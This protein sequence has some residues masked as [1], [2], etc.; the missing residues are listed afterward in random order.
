MPDVQGVSAAVDRYL[1][2]P[3]QQDPAV[4]VRASLHEAADANPETEAEL[5]RVSR[6][7]GVPL[8]SARAFPADVRRQALLQ[9]L[10]ANDTVRQFPRT[11]ALLADVDNARIAHDDIGNLTAIERAVRELRNVGLG[12]LRGGMSVSPALM[13]TRGLRAREPT[14]IARAAAEGVVGQTAG[15]LLSGIGTGL[16]IGARAIDRPVRRMFGNEVADLFWYEPAR[17]GGVALDPLASFREGGQA[18]EQL[19]K[20]IGP[21]SSERGFATDVA[22]GLGQFAG[23]AGAHILSGGALTLPMLYAQGL[24][25]FEQK[26]QRDQADQIMKDLGMLGAAG[27][28]AATEKWALDRVLGP[29]AVPVKSALAAAAARIGIAAASEGG[30]EMAESVGH[31]LLRMALTNPDAKID[32]LDVAYEGGVGA[33]VGG[34]ARSVLEAALHVRHRGARGDWQAGSAEQRAQ[35]LEQLQQLA[36]ASKT[37][38]RDAQT[39]Q[40]FVQQVA[41]EGGDTPTELFVAPQQLAG[42]LN[43]SGM[44][45]A[46]LQAVAP[47][48]AAQVAAA[49]PGSDIRLPLAEFVALGERAAPLIDHVR[50]GDGEMTRA[51][52]R[53]ATERAG[54]DFRGALDAELQ[55]RGDREAFRA[56]V[57]ALRGVIEQQFAAAGRSP[58]VARQEA[59]ILA[60]FYGAAAA[61]TGMSA[62]AFAQ[63]YRLASQRGAAPATA[64]S[65]TM[66]QAARREIAAAKAALARIEAAGGVTSPND[67]AAVLRVP[68]FSFWARSSVAGDVVASTA[69][70]DELYRRFPVGSIKRDWTLPRLNDQGVI[71]FD[72]EWARAASDE[73]LAAV[74]DLAEAQGA[75]AVMRGDY[76]DQRALDA[77]DRRVSAFGFE[78]Y[79]GLTEGTDYR[80]QSRALPIYIRPGGGITP[81]TSLRQQAW[82]GTPH[83][84]IERFSTDKIGTGEGA[85]AFAGDSPRAQISF[86]RDLTTAPSV[87]SFLKGADRSSGIHE[88]GHFFLQVHAD[89]AARIQAR[90]DAGEQVGDGERGIVEDM[91]TTL[92]W[93]GIRD[94]PEASALMQ[95]HALTLDQQRQ[96]HE[97]W[98]RGFERYAMEGKAPSVELMSAFSRFRAWLVDLYKRLTA[99]NVELSDD[100]RAVMGRMLATDEAVEEMEAVRNMAPMVKTAEDAARLGWTLDDYRAYQARGKEATDAAVSDLSARSQ[101]DL[102]WASRARD[103]ALKARQAEVE[104]LRRQVRAEVRLEVLSE[105]LYRAWTFLTGKGEPAETATAAPKAAG[106]DVT[107]DSLLNAIAHLGGLDREAARQDLGVHADDWKT[108]SGIFGK[109][110]FRKEG[111]LAPERMIE[112]LTD[113]A[114]LMP[115]DGLHEL[116]Q[117]IADELHGEPQY[118]AHHDYGRVQGDQAAQPLPEGV[119]FGKLST[120]M[121]REMYGAGEDAVWRKLSA[122]RMTSD[123]GIDPDVVAA[124]IMNDMGEPAF[125]SGDAL[126]QALAAAVPPAEVIE[127]RTDRRMLEQYGDIASPEA[128]QR[129][130]DEAVH[131]EARARFIADELRALREAGRAA[132]PDGKLSALQLAAAAKAYAEQ[133]VA[134]QRVRDLRPGQ[135]TAAEARSA[136]LAETAF[137]KGQTAEAAMHKRNQL[138]NHAAAK[139]ALDAKAEVAATI[140]SFRRFGKRINGIDAEHQ[141]QIETLLEAFNFRPESQKAADRRAAFAKWYA[142]QEE[143]GQAPDGLAEL[144]DSRKSYQDM[145]VAELRDLLAAVRQIEHL[146]RL[147]NRLLTAR[148]RRDFDAAADEAAASIRQHG[149]PERPVEMEGPNKAADWLAGFAAEHRKLSSYV[150]QMDGGAEDGPMHRL[151]GRGLNERSVAEDKMIEEAVIALEAIHRPVLALRGGLT[152]HRSKMSIPGVGSLTRAGRISFALNMGNAQ[153]RQRLESEFTPQQIDAVLRT[154]TPTELQFVNDIW[155]YLETYWPLIAAKERRL[156]GR[157]PEKVEAVP[158]EI[159]AAGG[160]VVPMTGGYYPIKYDSNRSD[161]AAKQ[162]AVEMAKRTLQGAWGH[163]T[164]QRGHTKARQESVSLPLRKDLRV[165]TEHVRQVTHDLSWHEWLIDANRLLNDRR[166]AGAIR[167]HYGPRAL[168]AIRDNID[169]IAAGDLK[170]MTQVDRAFLALRNN[171]TRSVMGASLRTAFLQPFGLLQSMARIGAGP[172]L[173]GLARWAGDAARLESTARKIYAKSDFMRRRAKTFNREMHEIHSAIDGKSKA[174]RAI[175]GGLFWLTQKMQLVSDIPTWLGQYEKTLADAEMADSEEGR[176][177]LEARAIEAAD[178]AVRESQGTGLSADLSLVQR[179]HP[180]LTQFYSYFNVTANLA[181]EKT[182]AT[183]FR[184]P[185]AVAGWLGDMALLAVLP[186]IVPSLLMHAL[187]GGGDDDEPG[188][189]AKNIAQWQAGYLLGMVVGARELSGPVGGFDYAG[190][191]AF[192]IFHDMGKAGAQTWQLVK[193]AWDGDAADGIDEPFVLAYARLLGDITGLPMTQILRSYKGWKAWDEGEEGAGPQSVLIG[194]PPRD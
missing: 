154:L 51:E 169:A 33:A 38:A 192:R 15:T 122:R 142:Q 20:R 178:R 93:F 3:T 7:T 186:S 181:A 148:D 63:T 62:Q 130:A 104:G 29:L 30:Q 156:T 117:K 78:P 37:L 164:T 112:A 86:P 153:N 25:Q 21:S 84:G 31:D 111:G 94:A 189:W 110:V 157:E 103:R 24:R 125:D 88:L 119:A 75:P 160:A 129:A 183:D 131:N 44:T 35:G 167:D 64:D 133:V 177:E 9:R 17:A 90:I 87:L 128:L 162:S 136:K 179:K 14:N 180:L 71:T 80:E 12:M 6:E 74:V 141:D 168:K 105:P 41:E 151:L 126:V 54:E 175:D 109:P 49:V 132:G 135:Y 194:P 193:S 121:L 83:R 2:Q 173:R 55:R 66:E 67:L 155:A 43:Q 107:R 10:D 134:S 150:R 19:G 39:V 120:P 57:D 108:P 143:T 18:L 139:A 158:F 138:A 124:S 147:K 185:R 5:R 118:S 40:S 116:E 81:A 60:E 46:E 170:A 53:D 73:D 98:A 101:R 140:R 91:R 97:Q 188:D 59:S 100:M 123:T 176:A 4:A 182:A 152:G 145:T 161:A 32:A 166:V 144:L 79:R 28:T 89:L 50:V 68:G 102:R 56:E 171:V 36:A 61:R 184:N 42:V 58:A 163:A 82:H 113:N 190:P 99:L 165:V 85:Q 106:L 187:T 191:P 8:G 45:I 172:T 174:V 23:Q 77:L 127:A 149:G 34:I 16:D 114:Y 69:I 52:A 11:A 27:W 65:A 22:A 26:A 137:A 115:G 92:E 76:G 159:N 13:A 48:T 96:Y 47:V 72:S 70:R 1:R 95:W 146:G